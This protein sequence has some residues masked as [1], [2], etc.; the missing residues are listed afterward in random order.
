MAGNKVVIVVIGVAVIKSHKQITRQWNFRTDTNTL[1]PEVIV[2]LDI[3]FPVSTFAPY[4]IEPGFYCT[5]AQI[6]K[7]PAI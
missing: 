1:T 5:S 6:E 2:S 7:C 4:G 3:V